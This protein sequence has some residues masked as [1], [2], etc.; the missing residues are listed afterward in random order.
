MN[1]LAN[2]YYVTDEETLDTIGKRLAEKMKEEGLSQRKL[3]KLVKE[4]GGEISRGTI[5]NIIQEKT[6]PLPGTLA[7]ICKALGC[8]ME[9]LTG[10]VEKPSLE[11][12]YIC[13]YTGLSVPAVEKLHEI[14]GRLDQQ[15]REEIEKIGG[16]KHSNTPFVTI[17][18][19]KS[20]I[21][22][23]NGI[24]CS[25]DFLEILNSYQKKTDAFDQV[26]IQSDARSIQAVTTYDAQH[27]SEQIPAAASISVSAPGK[28]AYYD[29][30]PKDQL[31]RVIINGLDVTEQTL[32][33][34]LLR[35]LQDSID[36]LFTE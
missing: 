25:P 15:S 18:D 22:I 29:N 12:Q 2:D 13:D 35:E 34:A 30:V 32:K 7:A 26:E 5:A 20:F 19:Y 24:I 17:R 6:N 33:Q 16:W 3:E 10:V 28:E 4:S 23:I 36:R 31:K 27:F 1:N 21:D 14:N 9:Y 11:L 8:K